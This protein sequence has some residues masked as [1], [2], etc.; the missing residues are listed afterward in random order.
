MIC[1]KLAMMDCFEST[2]LLLYD[3]ILAIG[4]SFFCLAIDQIVFLIL[5]LVISSLPSC[6]CSSPGQPDTD[7]GVQSV[8]I[9][10]FPVVSWIK[11]PR[12]SANKGGQTLLK[13][14]PVRQASRRLCHGTIRCF[15][16]Q[17]EL[18]FVG[19]FWYLLWIDRLFGTI[20][21][22]SSRSVSSLALGL[23]R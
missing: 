10:Y 22:S 23:L 9:H 1:S 17:F 12:H 8:K 18:S 4:T 19:A 13:P 21:N 11:V 5:L 15:G 2:S 20:A 6:A 3:F 7:E 16:R 14:S